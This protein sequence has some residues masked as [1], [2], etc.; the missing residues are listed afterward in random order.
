[1]SARAAAGPA[2]ALALAL[3]LSL[4]C[5]RTSLEPDCPQ[6]MT[7]QGDGCVC[8]TDQGCPKGYACQTEQA[9]CVCRDTTCCPAGY[10]F[11]TESLTCVCGADEC[12]PKNHRW[13]AASSKCICDNQDCCPDGYAFDASAEGCRCAAD[14]CCPEGF[15]YDA[16]KQQCVCN[17]DSC[18]PLDHRF[19]AVTKTCLCAKDSC[20]PV[21]YAYNA[22]I[23]ACV[24]SGNACCPSGFHYDVPT[25][26]CVCTNDA[27]CGG[28]LHNRCDIATG[29][30]RCKDDLGCGQPPAVSVPQYCNTLGFCQSLS[31][32]SD[33]DCPASTTNPTFCDI[34]TGTCIPVSKCT[35]DDHCPSGQ[36]CNTALSQCVNGCRTDD[37]CPLRQACLGGQCQVFCRDNQLCPQPTQFCN[38]SSGACFFQ[39]GRTDCQPCTFQSDCGPNASCLVFIAEG[40]ADTTFCGMGCQ[41]NADCPAGYDCDGVIFGC[42]D[43]RPCDQDPGSPQTITCK[44]FNVENEG[45]QQYCADQSGDPHEYFRRCGP[46]SGFCPATVSP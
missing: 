27:S 1:M 8:L 45:L 29:T 14:Q 43:S 12:C 26:R 4:G 22:T 25:N 41:E 10:A 9:L 35:L 36:I 18:C 40:Q 44:T 11:S 20:C 28:S 39:S 46:S 19:D 32:T 37:G 2:A 38:T 5:A 42:S 21:G 23:G 13:D 7:L 30:C 33:R 24:C 6:G 31:C 17:A 3:G 15:L 16:A 34:T